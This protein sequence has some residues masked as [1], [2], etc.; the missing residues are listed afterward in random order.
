MKKPNHE[1]EELALRDNLQRTQAKMLHKRTATR[2]KLLQE[3]D[4]EGDDGVMLDLRPR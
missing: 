3:L 1:E 2:I 4:P